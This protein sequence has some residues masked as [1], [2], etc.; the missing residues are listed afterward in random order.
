MAPPP[1]TAKNADGLLVFADVHKS[2]GAVHALRGVS[3]SVRAGEVHAIV[4][5][6]G[7]GKSTLLKILAGVQRPDRGQVLW[8]RNALRFGRPRE[9]L[10]AGIGTVYQDRLS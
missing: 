6:N 4:G 5:E 7:A 2:F 3:F 10:A 9:A 1:T 8:D